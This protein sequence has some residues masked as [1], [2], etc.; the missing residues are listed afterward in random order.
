[1]RRN[2]DTLRDLW[3]N[4]KST[5]IHIVTVPGGEDREKG[6]KKI[7]EEIIA[8]NLQNMGEEI[9]NQVQESQS[10]RQAK[11]KEEHTET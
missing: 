2:E 7:F 4:T 1:M 5:N 9:V 6:P 3:D 10:P 8:K 11:P